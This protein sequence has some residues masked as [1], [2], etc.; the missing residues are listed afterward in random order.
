MASIETVSIEDVFPLEDEYGNSMARRD[1]SLKANK[2]YVK[3]L[4]ESFNPETK[5]PDEPPVLVRD[6]GIYRIKA[7]NSRVEAMRLLRVKS[8]AAVVED[9]D[10]R[11][12]VEAA[13]RTDTKKTYEEAERA[14]IFK[15]L[16]LFGDDEYVSQV[17]GIDAERVKRIRRGSKRS[18]ESVEQMTMEWMEAVGEFEDDPEAAKAIL[19]AGA[20]GWKWEAEKRRSARDRAQWRAEMEAALAEAGVEVVEG[21][22]AGMSYKGLIKSPEDLDG[23]DIEPG[24][25]AEFNGCNSCAWLYFP[26]AGEAPEEKPDPE[27][28]RRRALA[29]EATA[30]FEE[31]D[32]SRS[33]WLAEHLLEIDPVTIVAAM[34]PGAEID[35]YE[36]DVNEFCELHEVDLPM[37]PAVT[38]AAFCHLSEC[39]V[40]KW[41]REMIADNC[42]DFVALTDAMELCGYEPPEAEQRLYQMCV[43]AIGKEGEDE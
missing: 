5:Q 38:I 14:D 17:T 13:W 32:A 41:S 6:G 40:G 12:V 7:G 24:A 20:S 10:E 30:R 19:D 43:D 2:D 18:G 15:A 11:A 3:R 42:R 26:A 23:F 1:Y 29:D 36:Y 4:A 25:A 31:A 22:P 28:E 21:S 27:E 8:F 34:A 9:G 16:T 33:A 39:P 35:V 37:G